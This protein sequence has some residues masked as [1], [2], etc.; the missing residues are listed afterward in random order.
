MFFKEVLSLEDIFEL[1]FTTS[2]KA[3]AVAQK[4]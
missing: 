2:P 4:E 3:E 1:A